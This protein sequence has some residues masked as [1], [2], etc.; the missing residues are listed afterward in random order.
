M[1]FLR[2]FK[3]LLYSIAI[4]NN[5]KYS[6]YDYYT[7][8]YK[9]ERDQDSDDWRISISGYYTDD[10]ETNFS[11][12]IPKKFR[13]QDK[14][15]EFY[16]KK[17]NQEYEEEEIGLKKFKL[18]KSLY[19]NDNEENKSTQI[20]LGYNYYSYFMIFFSVNFF[21]AFD[22]LTF[23]IYAFQYSTLN[24]L[25]ANIFLAAS[26]R[27]VEGSLFSDQTFLAIIISLVIIEA[28]ITILIL[29]LALKLY[30]QK[31]YS[32]ILWNASFRMNQRNK[33]LQNIYGKV[34]V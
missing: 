9:I 3:K 15:E 6:H 21:I 30:I 11:L 19:I 24:S 12:L 7:T 22:Y 10:G 18:K 27:M 29:F 26:Y 31:V 2:F 33:E 23:L 14:A 16:N 17:I 34:D 5:S 13:S 32:N 8:D 4:K 25:E 1:F 28:F 20:K